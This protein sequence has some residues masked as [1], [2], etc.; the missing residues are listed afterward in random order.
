MELKDILSSGDIARI[1]LSDNIQFDKAKLPGALGMFVRFSEGGMLG[2]YRA[3][4]QDVHMEDTLNT[5]VIPPEA[6]T[7]YFSITTTEELTPDNGSALFSADCFVLDN[8]DRTLW[9][10]FKVNGAVLG[11][12]ESV[13]LWK[14]SGHDHQ[15]V[16]MTRAMT[17]TVAA[18]SVVTCELYGESDGIQINGS[19]QVAKFELTAAGAN[20]VAYE[21]YELMGDNPTMKMS[22]KPGGI[23]A[24]MAVHD[25]ETNRLVANMEWLKTTQSFSLNLLDRITGVI[26]NSMVINHNGTATLLGKEILTEG[27]RTYDFIKTGKPDGQSIVISSTSYQPIAMLITQAR[28]AGT[29]EITFSITFDYDSTNKSAIFHWTIDNGATFEEFRV[30]PK[31]KTDKKALTYTFPIVRTTDAVFEVGINGKCESSG[32]TLTVDYASII[33]ERKA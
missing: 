22:V 31:D 29:Y 6:W 13:D 17:S 26:K 23:A 4:D 12:E 2:G 3:P 11:G 20:P 33:V 24:Q 30:E 28:K 16:L 9:M 15:Q 19:Y 10:R 14:D 21:Q 32:D 5:D 25:V 18:G 27:N 1:R 7:E 8:K